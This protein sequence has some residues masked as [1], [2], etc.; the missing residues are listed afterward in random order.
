[1]QNLNSQSSS[2]SHIISKLDE[3]TTILLLGNH[4]IS[5]I[6]S[7]ITHF[8]I[9]RSVFFRREKISHC[10]SFKHRK[11]P[12]PFQLSWVMHYVFSPWL[13]KIFRPTT[14]ITC[15]K[16]ISNYCYY[17]SITVD[18]LWFSSRCWFLLQ[19]LRREKCMPKFQANCVMMCY[20]MKCFHS[21]SQV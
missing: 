20:V 10:Q 8:P 13:H 7:Q 15:P 9:L 4:S 18:F 14:F 6:L 19:A 12:F 16:I 3:S 21:G 2:S 1:M 5:L 11:Y 17:D